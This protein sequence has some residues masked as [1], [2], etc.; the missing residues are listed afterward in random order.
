[1]AAL[2]EG[3]RPRANRALQNLLTLEVKVPGRAFEHLLLEAKVGPRAL[4]YATYRLCTWGEH[5]HGGGRKARLPV[6]DVEAI[7]DGLHT[8]IGRLDA[9]VRRGVRGAA[10]VAR[11]VN[12]DVLKVHEQIEKQG[13]FVSGPQPVGYRLLKKSEVAAAGGVR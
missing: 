13:W 7:L 12:E 11:R 3:S 6:E 1:V 10:D 9:D 5:R 8:L 2:R 4:L